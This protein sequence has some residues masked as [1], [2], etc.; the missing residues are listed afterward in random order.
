[1]R[2]MFLRIKKDKSLLSYS[3]DNYNSVIIKVIKDN[4]KYKQKY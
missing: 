4:H 1:M 2:R 3:N